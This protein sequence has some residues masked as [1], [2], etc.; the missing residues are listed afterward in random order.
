MPAAEF[1][2]SL[3]FKVTIDGHTSLGTWTKC[4]GLAVE[5]EVDD[6]RE[7]GNIAFVHHLPK[8]AK[9]T[10][11]TLVRPIDASTADVARWLASVADDMQRSTAQIAVLD[12]HG[13][14]VATWSFTGVFPVKWTGPSLDIGTNQAATE[15]LEL[16]HNGFAR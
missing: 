11:L 12:S 16:A 15:T 1:G 9:Y 3:R 7:G 2:L 5:Y 4:S 13:D 14:E 6:Y 10:N 8:G